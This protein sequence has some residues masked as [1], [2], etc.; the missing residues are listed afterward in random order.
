MLGN[1]QVFPGQG[2]VQPD[3]TLEL[4]CGSRGLEWRSTDPV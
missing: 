3:L 4:P 1:V 2:P